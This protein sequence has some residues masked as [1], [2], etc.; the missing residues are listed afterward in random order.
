MV[1]LFFILYCSRIVSIEGIELCL[2][3]FEVLRHLRGRT[4]PVL[5]ERARRRVGRD[6]KR[7]HDE[8]VQ[9]LNNCPVCR[10]GD[11]RDMVG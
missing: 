6:T 10:N 8:H 9:D 11:D 2:D 3:S 5:G 1:V 4:I 7:E